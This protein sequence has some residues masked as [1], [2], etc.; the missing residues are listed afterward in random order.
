MTDKELYKSKKFKE[1]NGWQEKE[2][3]HREDTRRYHRKMI[4]CVGLLTNRPYNVDGLMLQEIIYKE[5]PE[6]I[7][8]F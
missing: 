6:Q 1:C 4:R 2:Q 3:W 5:V 8:L 7:A